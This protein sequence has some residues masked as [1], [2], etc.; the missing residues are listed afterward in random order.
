MEIDRSVY[1][2]GVKGR[3]VGV[4][5]SVWV[6]KHTLRKIVFAKAINSG[7]YTV[8]HLKLEL[9]FQYQCRT[10]TL[11]TGLAAELTEI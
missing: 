4:V 2:Q 7:A 9:T 3:G 5:D 1:E 6:D 8:R 11:K 10:Q